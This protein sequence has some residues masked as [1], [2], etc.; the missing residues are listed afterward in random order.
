MANINAHTCITTLKKIKW[1][2]WVTECN[3]PRPWFYFISN[4]NQKKKKK[5]KRFS[6]WF[7]TRQISKDYHC[8]LDC[9]KSLF[10][11]DFHVWSW[12]SMYE[13]KGGLFCCCFLV[14]KLKNHQKII[15][16]RNFSVTIFF[17]TTWN[18]LVNMQ[19][20]EWACTAHSHMI[21]AR[22]RCSLSLA[23]STKHISH[24]L[25]PHSNF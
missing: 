23:V 6:T 14:L 9:F 2:N 21:W 20:C 24:D 18:L 16:L 10:V 17:C 15:N 22:Y 12:K 5:E 4:Q 11:Y 7:S 3:H 19:T 8:Q 13:E 1:G 25:W